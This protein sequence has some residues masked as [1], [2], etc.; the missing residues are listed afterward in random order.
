MA[1]LHIFPMTSSVYCIPCAHGNLPSVT[2]PF[3]P[4]AWYWKQSMLGLACETK[5]GDWYSKHC[6]Q[7]S[8]RV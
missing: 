7:F 5:S 6:T 8:V 2:R 3:L 4:H 1:L